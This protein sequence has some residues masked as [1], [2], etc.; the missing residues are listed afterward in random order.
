MRVFNNGDR[1]WVSKSGFSGAAT[2][3]SAD[4][5]FGCGGMRRAEVL[6]D[7]GETY[8]FNSDLQ[9]SFHFFLRDLKEYEEER[10][11]RRYNYA[12]PPEEDFKIICLVCGADDCR[13]SLSTGYYDDPEYELVCKNSPHSH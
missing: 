4:E 3:L 12:S 8:K 10:K 5:L 1:V 13:I 7:T 6:M 11:N 9:G 2:I